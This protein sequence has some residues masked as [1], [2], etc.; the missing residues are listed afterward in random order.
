[1]SSSGGGEAKVG[2]RER[3]RPDDQRDKEHH[4]GED[5]DRAGPVGPRCAGHKCARGE[6]LTPEQDGE[7]EEEEGLLGGEGVWFAVR[8]RTVGYRGMEGEG[9]S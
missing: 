5:Q 3:H 7:G 9:D 6:D 2:T 1:M 8:G 4:R